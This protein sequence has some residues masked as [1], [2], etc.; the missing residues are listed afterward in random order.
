MADIQTKMSKISKRCKLV[1][2]RMKRA[3]LIETEFIRDDS[4]GSKRMRLLKDAKDT[5]LDI[6]KRMK[7]IS[8]VATHAVDLITAELEI[9]DTE[10]HNV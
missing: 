2:E 7:C 4:T 10:S 6:D 9:S 1:S 5:V 8:G 3:R